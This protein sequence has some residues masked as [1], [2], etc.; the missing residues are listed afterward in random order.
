MNKNFASNLFFQ[1]SI[2]QKYLWKNIKISVFGVF[3]KNINFSTEFQYR[4]TLKKTGMCNLIFLIAVYSPK[5]D[6]NQPCEM[7]N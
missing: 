4:V 1:G 5:N 3:N 7:R 2:E 6:N